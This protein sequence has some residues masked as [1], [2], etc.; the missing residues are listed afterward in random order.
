MNPSL[1]SVKDLWF[2]SSR[3]FC[4]YVCLPWRNE[5]IKYL[6]NFPT[7]SFSSLLTKLPVPVPLPSLICCLGFV[8]S[9]VFRDRSS[10]EFMGRWCGRIVKAQVAPPQEKKRSKLFGQPLFQLSTCCFCLLCFFSSKHL[11]LQPVLQ[12]HKLN[13]LCE[14]DL[15]IIGMIF[16]CFFNL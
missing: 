11:C 9:A 10:M 14:T 3:R 8:T 5:A 4:C 2:T 6:Q 12:S 7:K 13:W 15:S 16:P 1:D